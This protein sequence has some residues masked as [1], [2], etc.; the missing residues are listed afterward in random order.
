[1][2]GGEESRA[3]QSSRLPPV[4]LLTISGGCLVRARVAAASE[5]LADAR[6]D[7]AA[8]F[9]SRRAVE[10]GV[11]NDVAHGVFVGLAE[12]H[13]VAPREAITA[14][15]QEEAAAEIVSLP[16][17]PNLSRESQARIATE[18]KDFISK[19]QVG[20]VSGARGRAAG[21]SAV[22]G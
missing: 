21:L 11:L 12:Y 6:N 14:E 16:M 15:L 20:A 10:G 3:K 8:V 5:Q 13:I 1:L 18:V 9:L 4:E 2:V 22:A 17:F 19:T 7:G